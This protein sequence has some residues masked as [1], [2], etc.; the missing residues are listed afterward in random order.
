MLAYLGKD[1]LLPLVDLMTNSASLVRYQAK[2]SA[3]QMEY[4]GTNARPGVVQ[5]I[6]YLSD[7]DV[8]TSAAEVLGW[9]QLESDITVPALVCVSQG[10]YLH[11]RGGFEA[12]E[13]LPSP[14]TELVVSAADYFPF[15]YQH[16]LD[17]QFAFF[18][19]H[20]KGRDT[21]PS[22][23][24]RIAVRTG[25]DGFSWLDSPTWPPAAVTNRTAGG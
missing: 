25:G 24:V 2:L 18:D 17:Q 16:C 4:L 6:H 15:M 10:L 22:P 5:L 14:D 19:R 9:L 20:L 21:P 11:A 23:R 1:A 7:P 8:A 13:A 12:F 3:P